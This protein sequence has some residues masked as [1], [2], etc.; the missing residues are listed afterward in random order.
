MKILYHHRIRSKDGQYVHVEELTNA[1]LADG[2]ELVW[3][4]PPAIE[5]E[6]FG[7]DAGFVA[8][9][10]ENIPAFIYEIMEFCYSFVD[11][12]RLV[13]AIRR[14]RPDCIYERYN[15]YWPS[16]IWAKKIFGL[17]LLL[18]IN[19]PLFDERRKYG[20]LRLLRFA[21]A[22][23]NYTWRSA[24]VVLPVTEVL[25]GTVEA[26][27]VDRDRIHVIHNGINIKRFANVPSR[28]DAKK[29]LGLDGRFVLGFAGFVREWHRLE[30]VLEVLVD[31]PQ[32]HLVL[33]GDGPAR[34][35]IEREAVRLGVADQLTI[36]GIV[37]RDSIAERLACFDIALQPSV[38]NYASPLKLFEYMQLGTAIIAP[39]T[40]NIR[41]ILVDGESALLFD[42]ASDAELFDAIRR[43][44]ADADLRNALGAGA[45][46]TISER[47]FTWSANASRVAALI[48]DLTRKAGDE[49]TRPA[50]N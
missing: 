5:K 41:E 40:A 3:V 24:D 6:E 11:F 38:V 9:L 33:V 32:L 46:Q 13:R 34:E 50:E 15:L 49:A 12:A 23:E 25:A 45:K 47:A 43:L 1:L 7:A 26:S 27:G 10:K 44:R 30:R 17:P 16:G 28:D 42:R 20:G 48:S 2:H 22:V 8:W 35:D 19:A 37:M 21:K 4:T 18:E 39:D 36:T 29:Q 31:D 14:E